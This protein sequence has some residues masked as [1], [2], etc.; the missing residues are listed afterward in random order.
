M[1]IY[2]YNRLLNKLDRTGRQHTHTHTHTHTQSHC[3]RCQYTLDAVARSVITIIRVIETLFFL[4]EE[5]KYN[6][7]HA[8]W[9]AI[10]LTIV[11]K[12]IQH[13]YRVYTV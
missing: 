8:I 6:Y 9:M 4:Y 2:V 5:G 3:G 1:R 13:I 12:L 11:I 10:N 7:K